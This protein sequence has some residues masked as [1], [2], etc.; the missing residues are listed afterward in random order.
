VREELDIYSRDIKD[1][2]VKIEKKDSPPKV[3]L[4]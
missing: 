3:N 4:V 1:E 2:Y